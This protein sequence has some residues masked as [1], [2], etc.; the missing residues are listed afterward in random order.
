MIPN[1]INLKELTFFGLFSLTFGSMVGSGIFDIPQNIAHK[2]GLIAV[3]ISWMITT[4]GVLS[5]TFVFTYLATNKPEIQN[6]IYGYAKH[7]FNDYIGFNSGW[8]YWLK[9]LL[10]NAS[11]VI[12]VFSMLSNLHFFNYFHNGINLI[13]LISESILIWIC[14]F[15]IKQG[16]KEAFIINIFIT[17]LKIII[18]IILLLIFIFAFKLDQFKINLGEIPT[19]SELLT[20]VKSAMF[21]TLWDFIGI[22]AACIYAIRAKN[23]KDVAKATMYGVMVVLII[24]MLIS[25]LPFG[26]VH[27]STLSNLHTPSTAGILSIIAGDFSG[28]LISI[29]VIISVLGALLAWCMIAT[30]IIYLLATDGAMPKFITKLNKKLVPSN[31]LL[32]SMLTL[33]IFI[34]FAYFTGSI[35]LIMIQLAT[36]LVLVPYLLVGIYA[37]KILIN[38]KKIHYFELLKGF[39]AVLYGIW[40]I[41]AGGL[42]YLLFS[43]VLYALGFFVYAYTKHKQQKNIFNTKIEFILCCLLNLLVVCILILWSLKIITL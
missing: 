20:Q 29:A 33:Q 36:S 6:G 31:A 12:Y 14:Y 3:I 5:L 21:V 24:D 16:I 22:E 25:I 13:S 19:F 41:Y 27:S 37:F 35:Y 32:I 15:L 11:Y 10:G 28:K 1:K 34:L 17:S 18:L 8:G 43:S 4:I 42:K 2:A 39:I 9:T 30:N 38:Q 23:M 7:G 26:I 40:L